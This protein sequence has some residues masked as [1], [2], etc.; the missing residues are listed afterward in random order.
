MPKSIKQQE[1]EQPL[2]VRPFSYRQITEEAKEVETPGDVRSQEEVALAS[3]KHDKRYKFL[4]D[5]I[6]RQAESLQSLTDVDTSTLS[7]EE[8]GK[9]FIV[10]RFGAEKLLSIVNY[11]DQLADAIRITEADKGKA[12]S[13][14]SDL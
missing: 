2:P 8:I 12:D 13:T 5:F 9:R 7:E 11:V 14:A 6:R 10:A 1:D 3:L 4:E